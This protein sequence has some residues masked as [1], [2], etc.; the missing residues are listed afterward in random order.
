MAAQEKAAAVE[1]VLAGEPYREVAD[2]AGVAPRAVLARR[3]AYLEKGAAALM[4]GIDR[5]GSAR[6]KAGALPDDPEEL[7]RRIRELQFENDLMREVVE[8]VKKKRPR[9]R[10]AQPV[11]Q[12]EGGAD[13]RDKGDVFSELSGV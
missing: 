10:P 5:K 3:R 8:L 2:A 11:E 1:L 9:R 12:G 7:R 6:G 4:T 13:R